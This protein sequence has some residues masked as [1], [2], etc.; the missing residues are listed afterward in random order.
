MRS[1]YHH[2]VKTF[3]GW[4]DK[5]LPD[6]TVIWTLP[7]GQI[8]ATTPAGAVLFPALV[9]PTGLVPAAPAAARLEPRGGRTAMMPKR[10]YTRAVSR[11][12]RI[13]SER[14][15]N[16]QAARSALPANAVPNPN[17]VPRPDADDPPF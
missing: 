8:Y 13:A 1:R 15:S 11:A 10:R 17:A 7:D 2:L 16:R 5:Q 14:A 4:R 3:W 9:G 12:H 6:G